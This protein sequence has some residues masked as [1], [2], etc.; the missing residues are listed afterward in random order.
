M[1]PS[2]ALDTTRAEDVALRFRKVVRIERCTVKNHVRARDAP[3]PSPGH[4][5]ASVGSSDNAG[6]I[7]RLRLSDGAL[8]CHACCC[9]CCCPRSRYAR[10]HFLIFFFPRRLSNNRMRRGFE[11]GFSVVPR[12]RGCP[13][14]E[15]RHGNW[16]DVG[17]RDGIRRDRRGRNER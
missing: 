6:P 5:I 12:S 11:K 1:F 7:F 9:C 15:S 4:S 2:H 3:A 13:P 17:R 14:L 8:R 16:S 10:L